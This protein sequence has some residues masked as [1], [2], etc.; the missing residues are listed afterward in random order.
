MAK[1]LT[2]LPWFGGKSR[3]L[4]FLLPLMPQT[5]VYVEPFGGGASILLNRPRSRTEVYADMDE[6]LVNFLTEVRN[7]PALM[8]RLIR[9][10]PFSRRQLTSDV[11]PD[12]EGDSTEDA[13]RFFAGLHSSYSGTGRN[14]DYVN[15]ARRKSTQVPRF[16]QDWM[17]VSKRLH[18]V[19]LRYDDAFAVMRDHDTSR[20]VFYVDPPY[21]RT[22][23]KSGHEG[24]YAH[25]FHSVEQH[26]E[27]LD[28][29][30]GLR[31][32]VCLSGYQSELYD[33]RLKAPRWVRYD[34]VPKK[35]TVNHARI[36]ASVRVESAWVKQAR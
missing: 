15:W 28:F 34:N 14:E 6:R 11:G 35:V 26:K 23:M 25:G 8:D 1:P 4:D 5:K 13:R 12:P 36:D 7:N 27:L 2:A 18:G 32:H 29:L 9:T 33:D 16:A 22:T 21:L 10:T 20:T 17:A 3:Y 24:M 19:E 31:G 30:D